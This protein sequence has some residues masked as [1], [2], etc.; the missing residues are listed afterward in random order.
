M[1]Q[2]T[3]NGLGSAG[4]IS[5]FSFTSTINNLG[6]Y[7][8]ISSAS[9]TSSLTGL[10]TFKYVSSLSQTSSLVGLGTLGYAS[11]SYVINAIN[12][13]SSNYISSL[14]LQ[15]TI[16]GLGTLGYVSSASLYSSITNINNSIVSSSTDLFNKKQ[17]IYLNDAGALVI[18]GSNI[19]VTVSTISSFYYYN[20]FNNSTII[21]KGNNNAAT[22]Y[23]VGLDFYVSTLDTQ[24]DRFSSFINSKTSLSLEV[25]P[26]IIFPQ[27][28][29]NSN[30]QIYHVSSFIQYNGSTINLQQQTK[31]LAMNNSASNLFQQ[32]LRINV[33]G[34]VINN[35]YSYPYQLNHRF[36][37]V[38][39]FGTN[40]G[41]A[42]SNVQLY[43]DSTSS[44]YLSIQN[45][46]P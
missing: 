3:I 13:A 28:N 11:T 6:S 5:S 26:N 15:S 33:P 31:F 44:Y 42:N 9:L 43:M 22:A 12:N 20:S 4:Y 19:N 46:A 29:T 16:N 45:I 14:S 40:V 1:L 30:P 37:N 23:N 38:Y 36:I 7:G 35:N 32:R 8:Y 2:S 21:Y 27:I 24:L 34:S 18:G 39:A 10:G 41:F 17:N 25:Y